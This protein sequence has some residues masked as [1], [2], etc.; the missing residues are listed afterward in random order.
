MDLFFFLSVSGFFSLMDSP[1]D[2]ARLYVWTPLWDFRPQTPCQCPSQTEI[3][4]PPLLATSGVIIDCS[5]TV[6]AHALALARERVSVIYR[7]DGWF[8]DDRSLAATGPCVYHV[9]SGLL[10]RTVRQ[11]QRVRSS[12]AGANSVQRRSFGLLRTSLQPSGITHQLGAVARILRLG[13]TA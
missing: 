6:D 10:Q 5:S 4:D 3:L 1:P 9:A 8:I 2:P 13:P 11:L 12:T 7:S